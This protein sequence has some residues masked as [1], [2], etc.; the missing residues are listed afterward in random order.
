VLPKLQQKIIKTHILPYTRGLRSLA[1]KADAVGLADQG[2]FPL[3]ENFV[4]A[5]SDELSMD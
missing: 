5:F 2:S 1:K 4:F 3:R